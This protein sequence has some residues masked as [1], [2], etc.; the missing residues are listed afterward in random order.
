MPANKL[1]LDDFLDVKEALVVQ[2]AIDIVPVF[3][4][5]HPGLLSLLVFGL[6]LV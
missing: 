2:Y 4:V 6:Q 5:F 1:C 3:W